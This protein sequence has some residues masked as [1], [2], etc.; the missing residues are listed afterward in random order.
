MGSEQYR[1]RTT[2]SRLHKLGRQLVYSR[3]ALWGL[4][5]A[6]FLESIIVPIPL[7][8]ILI[9]LMQARRHQ[10]FLLAGIALLGCLLGAATGYAVGYFVFDAIGAQLVEWA[11]SPEQFERVRQSMETGG[12]WFVLSVGV[13]PIPFQIAMLAAGATGFSFTLFMV[14]SAISR[15]IRY[16]GL[17]LLVLVAGNKAQAI[18]ERHKVKTAVIITL[19]VAGAWGLSL[20]RDGAS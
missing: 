18:F 4:G 8:A 13:I 14:A 9:P 1:K 16:F 6:S 19:L 2:I 3:H 12:F 7:E 20:I 15:A 10:L 5:L 17:A 11:S